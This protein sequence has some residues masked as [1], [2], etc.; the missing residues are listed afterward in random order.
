MA[1]DIKD[2]DNVSLILWL[3]ILINFQRQIPWKTGIV[4]GIIARRA[5]SPDTTYG[6][7]CVY[8]SSLQLPSLFSVFPHDALLTFYFI[9]FHHAMENGAD[10]VRDI[11]ESS[12]GET[13]LIV[14][15]VP[16]CPT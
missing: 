12:F 3:I 6:G 16:L 14:V 10:D 11:L 1:R 15:W 13:W 5:L 7:M 9:S 4:L 2:D 8:H